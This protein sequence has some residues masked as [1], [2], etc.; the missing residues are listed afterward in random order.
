M[1]IVEEYWQGVAQRLQVEA[2]VFNRL[3]MHNAE[4]GRENESSLTDIVRRFLPPTVGVGTGIVIDSDG[5]RSQQCD[6]IVFDQSNSPNLLAQT[7]Q[8]LFPVETVRL[9]IEVKTTVTKVE[10]E[11]VAAKIGSLNALSWVGKA[12]NV[13][14]A[15][16]GYSCGNSA[17]T[18]VSELLGLGAD[19]MPRATCVMRPGVFGQSLPAAKAGLV[20]LHKLDEHGVSISDSWVTPESDGPAI[21][22]GGSS[23]PTTRIKAYGKEKVVGNPGRALLLF[24]AELLGILSE[25]AGVEAHWLERYLSRTAREL[26]EPEDS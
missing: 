15:L 23:Y 25:S 10:I 21:I 22:I 5:R 11:D 17:G 16:F 26:I 18:I 4:S 9:V 19:V 8:M 1:S 7:S 14:F 6:L 13:P 20:A 24:C 2:D 12:E 3:I